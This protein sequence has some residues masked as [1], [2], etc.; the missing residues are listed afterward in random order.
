MILSLTTKFVDSLNLDILDS[1]TFNC[2]WSSISSLFYSLV[3]DW[4][5]RIGSCRRSYYFGLRIF[6]SIYE[7]VSH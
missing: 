7:Q 5:P 6:Q 2:Y 4:R 3:M 1:P